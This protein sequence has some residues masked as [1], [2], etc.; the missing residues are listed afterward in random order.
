M[1]NCYLLMK[2]SAMGGKNRIS[3]LLVLAVLFFSVAKP[4]EAEATKL[5]IP[6]LT[7]KP[8]DIVTV[9]VKVD[10]VDDLAG[11]KIVLQ[12]DAKLLH[13]EKIVKSPQTSPLL[14]VVNDKN[15]GR[16]IVVMAGAAGVSG[17]DFPLFLLSFKVKNGRAGE[18]NFSFGETQ[19]MSSK[20]KDI[21]HSVEAKPLSIG[22]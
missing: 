3:W 20:L 19:L 16:V 4:C 22:K 9:P 7:A 15:P 21:E 17:E 1:G 6:A 14:H 11:L 13:Y 2:K 10:K 12:Y 18:T 8:G 5:F